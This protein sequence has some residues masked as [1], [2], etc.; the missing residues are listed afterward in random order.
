[1]DEGRKSPLRLCEWFQINDHG[2]TAEER[3][4]VECAVDEWR[5]RN[6]LPVAPLSFTGSDGAQLCA[7]QYVG[8][9]EVGDITIEIY[10]K[11]DASLIETNDRQPLAT[12]VKTNSVMH[13]LLWMLQVADHQDVAETG[14]GHLEETPTSFIDLF[15]YLLGKNLLAE[16]E[17]GVAH[18]YVTCEDDLT[19]VRGR[20]RLVDQLTRNWNRFDRVDCT[21]DEFTPNTAVN[22]LFKCACRFL[23]E[24]V[25]HSEAARLLVDCQRLLDEV[26]DVSPRT[27]LDGVRNLRFDRSVERFELPLK[28]A[29]RLLAGIGHNLGAG[30]ENTFVF[31]LDMN[32]VFES[33]VHAVLE[34]YFETAVEEQK[35]VGTLFKI[36]TGGVRQYA[37]CYWYCDTDVWIGDAKYK[38]LAKGQPRA[39]RFS[40]LESERE[41]PDE[42]ASLAGR[43]LSPGD[44]RQLTVYAELARTRYRLKAPPNLMLLYPFVG[45]MEDCFSDSATAWNGSEFFLVPVRMKEQ[46]SVGDAIR[47]PNIRKPTE[48]IST[49]KAL[50]SRSQ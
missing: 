20:I 14:A 46:Y 38:H 44:I 31:L 37:D 10:P 13:D 11:L 25:N 24:K 22:R 48:C 3:R 6:S 28:L 30:G 27:A 17:R 5:S 26:D 36:D 34:A 45:S 43:L 16:L 9:V 23:G 39:L 19:V 47:L 2:L 41:Q 32:K 1:M 21:W 7:Q 18:A 15:A 8:V 29:Q 33:Y 40:D 42:S 4:D 49:I 12:D 35:I 50:D